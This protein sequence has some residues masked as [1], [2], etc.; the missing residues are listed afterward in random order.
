MEYKDQL[1]DPRWQRKRLEI[2][3]RD[4]FRCLVC[5]SGKLELN[6]HHLYY[7]PNTMIWEYDNEGL[8]TVCKDHHNQLHKDLPKLAGIIAFKI[9][10]KKYDPNE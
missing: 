7:L 6:V 3:Q 9:L 4:G 8:V 2:M 1:K 5:D 10:C